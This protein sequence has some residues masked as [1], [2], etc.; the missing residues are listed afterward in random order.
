MRSIVIALPVVAALVVSG[1]G[2]TTNPPAGTGGAG[3]GNQANQPAAPA[4]PTAADVTGSW[5]I[6]PARH[7]AYAQVMVVRMLTMREQPIN[8]ATVGEG[9]A[10]VT[11]AIT[12][13][14]PVFTFAEGGVFTLA[15]G[16]N[17]G[18]TGTWTLEGDVVKVVGGDGPSIGD[19]RVGNGRL[20]TVK[21][22][23][24]EE[25]ASLIRLP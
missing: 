24:I 15:M 7:G 2:K 9:L 19:F 1:C 11:G 14:P 5:V 10:Q 17:P 21:Q 16:T 23:E 20:T 13:S 22:N 12:A 3:S 18:R 6:D 8:D 4:A 25:E